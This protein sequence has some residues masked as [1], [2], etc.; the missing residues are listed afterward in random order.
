M[1]GY[2]DELESAPGRDAIVT[3]DELGGPDLDPVRWTR[4]TAAPHG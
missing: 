4:T 2:G 3:Y 1:P